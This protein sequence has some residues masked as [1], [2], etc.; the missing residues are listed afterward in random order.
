[1][2]PLVVKF[3]SSQ[4]CVHGALLMSGLREHCGWHDVEGL[5]LARP[6]A[7]FCKVSCTR[8][9]LLF[10]FQHHEQVPRRVLAAQHHATAVSLCQQPARPPF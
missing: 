6:F 4:S 9:A 2:S 8:P 5:R 7:A 10:N 1:M 3:C